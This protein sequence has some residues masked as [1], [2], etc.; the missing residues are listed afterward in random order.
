MKEVNRIIRSN[1][2]AT[3]AELL[4]QLKAAGLSAVVAVK[5]LVPDYAGKISFKGFE[6]TNS[7]QRIWRLK[8]RIAKEEK[9]QVRRESGAEKKS[10]GGGTVQEDT[11]DNRL[12]IYFEDIPPV[13]LFSFAFG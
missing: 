6:L 8:E 7:N 1:K 5:L 12:R 10:F 2:K 4:P 3:Y 13:D 9:I 11:T